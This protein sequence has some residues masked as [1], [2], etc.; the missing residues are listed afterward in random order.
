MLRIQDLTLTVGSRVL[1]AE[2]SWHVHPGE[3]VALLGRNGTGKSTLL[4]AI[5]GEH[6]HDEGEI[7]VRKGARVGTLPQQG[8]PAGPETVWEVARSWMHR[9]LE[10]EARLQAAQAA[11][12]ARD[13]GASEALGEATEAF[14]LAGGYAWEERIGELL[15]G[16]GFQPEQWHRPTA[17]LSGGWRM[18]VALAR[19]LLSEPELL[20]LDE[21]TNHLDLDGRTYLARFLSAYPGTVVL[22]SHDRHLLDAVPTRVAEIR[23]QQL[24][25]WT[26]NLSSWR[27]E[28]ARRD[29]DHEVRLAA[30]QA[31]IA[32]LERFV[33]R[34]R[35]KASKASQAQSRV[36]MLEKIDRLEAHDRVAEARLV[37]PEP[38]PGSEE[39]LV[40]RDAAF[41]WSGGPDIVS[42]VGLTLTRG[43]R[44]AVLG[45]NG[46]GKSTLLRGLTGELPPR[47][48]SR[49]LGRGVRVGVFHQDLAAA[50]P[51]EDSAVQYVTSVVPLAPVAR[52]RSVLGALGLRGDTHERP[53]GKLSGGEKARVA[54][55]AFVLRPVN[56]MLLDEPTNHLDAETVEVLVDALRA[57]SGAMV[58]VTHDRWLVEQVATHV[59]HVGRAGFRWHEGVRPA[60]FDLG[61]ADALPDQG[62]AAPAEAALSHAERKRLA[63]ERERAARRLDELQEAVI[64]EAEGALEAIDADLARA[65]AEGADAARFEELG[66]ARAAQEGEVARLYEEW[67]RLEELLAEQS[68]D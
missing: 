42:G 2:A 48:G 52:V 16:L 5:T 61:A 8:V 7:L 1:L 14:R 15:H 63:R 28:R 9:L 51:M 41:G 68:A 24:E 59:A 39:A 32:R 37:L 17:E 65:A 11:A 34:F 67:E 33:E 36:K 25:T 29:A 4:K 27:K 45:A 60:D 58:V 13:P 12:E 49:R 55:A 66:R 20:L 21:P 38:P 23:R 44:L 35:Y 57:W 18:R 26:G 3:K 64:P 46:A 56:L 22:I 62:A 50:L 43:M 30:Q 47:R 31:E 19:L 6:E 53:L 40:L 54:L 10:L